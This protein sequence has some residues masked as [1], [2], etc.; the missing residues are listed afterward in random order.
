MEYDHNK[1]HYMMG[2]DYL[3]NIGYE[4][5][6]IYIP[7]VGITY[8]DIERAYK[9]F[10]NMHYND[11]FKPFID[12]DEESGKISYQNMD[13]T[14]PNIDCEYNLYHFTGEPDLRTL[15]DGKYW[16]VKK[17]YKKENEIFFEKEQ[18]VFLTENLD[19]NIIIFSNNNE[20]VGVLQS[21][22]LLNE[23]CKY[24]IK[25]NHTYVYH[26]GYRLVSEVLNVEY[27]KVESKL[28]KGYYYLYNKEFKNIMAK[29]YIFN[30]KKNKWFFRLNRKQEADTYICIGLSFDRKNVEHVWIIPN[31]NETKNLSSLIVHNTQDSLSEYNKY[32][33]DSKPYNKM[34]KKIN[35]EEK[36]DKKDYK[37]LIKKEKRKLHNLIKKEE[38]SEKK[39]NIEK[40]EAILNELSH[41][42]SLRLKELAFEIDFDKYK[43]ITKELKKLDKEQFIL[44]DYS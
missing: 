19:S 43:G 40:K 33:V 25:V 11:D 7:S 8:S 17:F 37:K 2:R 39:K 15:S 12:Y 44:S 29:A 4:D 10:R 34:L 18:F 31:I 22:E 41:L 28:K 35:K 1:E 27:K 38:N 16:E 23:D 36:K 9:N 20:F 6:D 13:T 30:V 5:N 42:E 3:I 14:Y 32:E 21:K 24:K 26:I